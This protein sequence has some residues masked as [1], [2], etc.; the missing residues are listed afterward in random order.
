MRAPFAH[1]RRP[2]GTPH[3]AP[4]ASDGKSRS[5]AAI[6]SRLQAEGYRALG[7]VRG[8]AIRID[9][10][11][12]G[13]PGVFALRSWEGADAIAPGSTVVVGPQEV[14]VDA[15]ILE[16]GLIARCA[17]SASYL[18]ALLEP[19]AGW[20]TQDRVMPVLMFAHCRV[21]Q[22]AGTRQAIR[23]IESGAF[24]T[25]IDSCGTRFA[26]EVVGRLHDALHAHFGALARAL[27]SGA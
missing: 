25:M 14:K 1:W 15:T 4:E 24:E 9:C 16:T 27:P 22:A 18:R 10:I 12:I 26:P 3:R 21:E 2:Q 11:L 13:A 5:L 20:D 19:I 17:I 8:P 23:A 7:P 6:V